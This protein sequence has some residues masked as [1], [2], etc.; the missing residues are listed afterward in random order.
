MKGLFN[1]QF[2]IKD[3]VVYVLEVNPRA[4][5]TA[6][7]VSKA[8]GS[9]CRYAAQIAAGRITGGTQPPEEPHVDGFTDR[10]AVLR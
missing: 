8:T 5:R 7:F 3:D 10:K 6:P 1:I 2:A 4:S 9:R